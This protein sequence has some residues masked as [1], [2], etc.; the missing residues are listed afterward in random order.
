VNEAG[1]S[2]ESRSR[3]E[4][5][6]GQLIALARDES[7]CRVLGVDGAVAEQVDISFIEDPIDYVAYDLAAA[8]MAADEDFDTSTEVPPLLA[9]LV[10]EVKLCQALMGRVDE[11]ELVKRTLG[12]L[13][14]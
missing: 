10:A 5:L 13:R 7:A 9:T 12:N 3:V 2:W 8:L 11:A 4:K 1:E 14:E 6:V